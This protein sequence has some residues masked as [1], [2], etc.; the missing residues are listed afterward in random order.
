MDHHRYFTVLHGLESGDWGVETHRMC[1]KAVE[2]AA[3]YD[4][5]ELCNLASFEVLFRQAQLVEYVYE[6]ERVAKLTGGGGKGKK[7]I[8]KGGG[9]LDEALVFTGQHRDAGAVML[10]LDLMDFVSKEVERD[11]NIMKQVRKAREERRALNA[12][13]KN[14]KKDGE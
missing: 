7:G 1:L 4:H 9:M 8:G 13:N 11:A 14:N 6:Q 2:E 5:L 3:G 10:A 12:N